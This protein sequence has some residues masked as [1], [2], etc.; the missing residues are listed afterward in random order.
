M[1][2][3]LRATVKKYN[4]MFQ[5]SAFAPHLCPRPKSSLI[6]H[7][8]NDSLSAG[9]LT[10]CHSDVA[11]TRQYLAQNFNRPAPVARPR[12]C[13]LGT[14]SGMLGSHGLGAIIE[15]WRLTTKLL[16]VVLARCASPL[17]F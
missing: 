10:N 8:I 17:Y 16:V 14:K 7:L 3:Q 13:N 11:S 15:V 6:N 1:D 9:C 12:F 5:L 4:Q 2:Q